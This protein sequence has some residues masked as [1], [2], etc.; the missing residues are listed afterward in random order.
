VVFS[1]AE[2]DPAL[3]GRAT[4]LVVEQDALVREHLSTTLRDLGYVVLEASS[5]ELALALELREM[6]LDLVISDLL[7]GSGGGLRLADRLRES[8]PDLPV[9]FLADATGIGAPD[10]ETVLQK[11]VSELGLARAILERLGRLPS[12]TAS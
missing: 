7:L 1:G 11:P 4:L 3:H 9:I 8:R 2:V 12:R 6:P 10:R 5:A